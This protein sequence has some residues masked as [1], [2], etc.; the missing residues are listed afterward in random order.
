L[1][2]DATKDAEPSSGMSGALDSQGADTVLRVSVPGYGLGALLMSIASRGLSGQLSLVTDVGRR[3][4]HLHSG[5]PV[6]AQSSLVSERLGAIGVRHGFFTREDVARALAHGREQELELGQGLLDLGVV[7]PPRLFA[8]LGV[9]V[10]EIIAAACG[11]APQR[12]RLS[13]GNTVRDAMMLRLHPLTAVMMAVSALP[14]IERAKLLAELAGQQLVAEPL[15]SIARDWLIDLGYLGELNALSHGELT[16]ASLRTRLR[17]RYR[18]GAEKIFDPGRSPFAAPGARELCVLPPSA[19]GVADMVALTLLVSISM[20]L[21]SAGEAGSSADEPLA[22]TA[23]GLRAWLAR[24]SAHGTDAELLPYGG[25]P[26]TPADRAIERYLRGERERSLALASAV[27][28]PSVEASDPAMPEELLRL[29][30]TL[31]SQPSAPTVLGVALDEGADGWMKG[32]A[33]RSELLSSFAG[34][35][36]SSL[37][38]CRVAELR[39]RCDDA[40]DALVSG[41]ALARPSA[42]P[43]STLAGVSSPGAT[44]A[45]NATRESRQPSQ[46]PRENRQPSQAP[47]GTDASRRPPAE[48]DPRA[49]AD[50]L[51]SRVEGLMRGGHWGDVQRVLSAQSAQPLSFTLQVARAMAL[52]E[53]SRRRTLIAPA[54]LIFLLGVT[55]GVLLR[56]FVNFRF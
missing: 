37:V 32:F 6:F 2:E 45:A 51:A 35:D 8:L 56:H 53:L 1:H 12:A 36:A 9:Q 43:A 16:L 17:A 13:T 3:T 19:S 28:G 26:T 47:R 55:A 49:A 44:P 15:P 33:R 46:A 21:A 54:L 40:L 30:V 24:A 34:G 52:R 18:A 31:R 11:S 27:W 42:L 29:Y 10:R 14:P 41:T 50:A 22:N 23:S 25:P 48:P 38:R 39:R 20:R 7:D 4:I 5:L